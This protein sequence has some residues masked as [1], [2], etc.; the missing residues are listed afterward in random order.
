MVDIHWNQLCSFKY[1]NLAST[2]L[3]QFVRSLDRTCREAGQANIGVAFPNS[4]LVSN[5][6]KTP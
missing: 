2:N 5:S 3:A 4:L 1:L 6:K